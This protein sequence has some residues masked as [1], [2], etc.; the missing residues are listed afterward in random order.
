MT[1]DASWRATRARLRSIPAAPQ[2][3]TGSQNWFNVVSLVAEYATTVPPRVHRLT[4]PFRTYPAPFRKLHFRARDGTR[5]AAWLGSPKVSEAGPR[6]G[7]VLVPGLYTSKDNPRIRARAVR[8]LREWG[9]HVLCLDLRGVGE[10][11]RAYSTPGW[12]EAE[13]IIDAIAEFR[14]RTTVGRVHLYAE[15]LAA[16]A[17]IVAAGMEGRAGRR[18]VDGRVLVTSAY[19]D[20]ARIVRL[21]GGHEE[22][23]AEFGRDFALV[24][25]TFN[26]LLRLQGYRGGNFDAYAHDAARHYGVT[27]DEFLRRSSPGEFVAHVNVPLL[28][29][30]SL[31]DGLVPVAQA[32]ELATRAAGNPNVDVWVLPWGYHCLYEMAEPQWYWNVLRTV[33]VGANGRH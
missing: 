14:A 22:P 16:S 24:R 2:K 31:D 17:A 21:Y 7:V 23:P 27:F 29:V 28:I 8:L 5:L 12:K 4:L 30:H 10:S 15:S 13:D 33:F 9:L 25:R 3:V 26:M 32:E 1:T 20:A 19:A 11:E 18:L 6:D